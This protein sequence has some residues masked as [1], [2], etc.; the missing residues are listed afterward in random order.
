MA[1]ELVNANPSS[2]KCDVAFT[3]YHVHPKYFPFPAKHVSLRG[4]E[5][6]KYTVVDVS[7]FSSSGSVGRIVEEVEVSRALFELYEGGIVSI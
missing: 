1:G 5:E 3:R 7:H 6:E 2:S 4:V